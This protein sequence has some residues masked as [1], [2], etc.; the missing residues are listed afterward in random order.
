[1][2]IS[3]NVNSLT[4]MKRVAWAVFSHKLSTDGKPE[5]GFCIFDTDVPF[6]FKNSASWA[7]AH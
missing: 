3:R 5:C 7:L 4:A 6:K 1:M 2:A